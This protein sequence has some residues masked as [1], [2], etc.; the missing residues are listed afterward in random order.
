MEIQ[1]EMLTR[2]N[3]SMERRIKAL[4]GIGG[5]ETTNGSDFDHLN[6][7]LNEVTEQVPH[8]LTNLT[9]AQRRKIFLGTRHKRYCVVYSRVPKQLAPQRHKTLE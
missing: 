5:N 6:L 4:E 9:T 3:T 1:K 8:P 7:K 2:H